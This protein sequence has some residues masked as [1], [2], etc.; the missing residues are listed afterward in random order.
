M[1]KQRNRK[2]GKA[3]ELKTM[4]TRKDR[5]EGEKKKKKKQ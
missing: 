1:N 2:N 5:E 3:V 4:T